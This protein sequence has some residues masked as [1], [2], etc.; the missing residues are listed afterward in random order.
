MHCK[1]H[2]APHGNEYHD[3]NRL[4]S[5]S[6]TCFHLGFRILIS[7]WVIFQ[8]YLTKFDVQSTF[9]ESGEDGTDSL[10]IF[11][12]QMHKETSLT[13]SKYS[14]LWTGEKRR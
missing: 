2:I 4:I 5:D 1:A 8:F 12:K 13:A 3:K 10:V 11:K 9:L 7:I 14:Q 6:V